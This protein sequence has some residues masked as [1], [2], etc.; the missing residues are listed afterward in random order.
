[1]SKLLKCPLYAT[2]DGV[3]VGAL[4]LFLSEGKQREKN[5]SRGYITER[6]CS[7]IPFIRETHY[8]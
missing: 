8:I 1:M 4:L 5:I 3:S 7:P 6:A 2:K